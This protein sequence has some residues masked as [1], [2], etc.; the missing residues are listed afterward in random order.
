MPTSIWTRRRT[1]SLFLN[2]PEKEVMMESKKYMTTKKLTRNRMVWV[3][4]SSG[5]LL[6]KVGAVKVLGLPLMPVQENHHVST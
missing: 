5:V 1:G 2:I 4:L 6:L 3:A